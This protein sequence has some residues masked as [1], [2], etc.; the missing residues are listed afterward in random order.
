MK[1]WNIIWSEDLDFLFEIQRV[2]LKI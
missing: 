1:T 2:L